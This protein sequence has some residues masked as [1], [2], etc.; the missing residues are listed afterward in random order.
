MSLGLLFC[1]L[2]R[3]SPLCAQ[4]AQ[5]AA[6]PSAVLHSQGNFL[7][8]VYD[9]NR[10]AYLAPVYA[11]LLEQMVDGLRRHVE[12]QKAAT[13]E[14]ALDHFRPYP[15]L[16]FRGHPKTTV[17]AI[18]DS[19]VLQDHP[20]LKDNIQEVVDFTGEG[21]ADQCG[22][23][24][25]EAIRHVWFEPS[26]KLLILK[27]FGRS[28]RASLGNLLGAI[29]YLRTRKDVGMVFMAGGIDI[30][31]YPAGSEVCRLAD[32][33]SAELKLE[34]GL[35]VATTG[36]IGSSG[37][38]C[39]AEA[40]S[41]LPY[42]VVD[43]DTFV[44]PTDIAGGL[45]VAQKGHN[46]SFPDIDPIPLPSFY[47]RFGRGLLDNGLADAATS[48]AR[49]GEQFDDSYIEGVR[50]E[51][52]ALFDRRQPDRAFELLKQAQAKYPDSPIIAGETAILLASIGRLQEAAPLFQKAVSALPDDADLLSYASVSLATQG[53]WSE[54]VESMGRAATLSAQHL[55]DLIDIGGKA[56]YANQF[57]ASIA[58]NETAS[59]LDPTRAATL[60]NIAIAYGLEGN[61]QD[62]LK[63]LDR[64]ETQRLSFDTSEEQS[65]FAGARAVL[66]ERNV[67]KLRV[68]FS[69]AFSRP[70]N[71]SAQFLELNEL[72]GLQ[73]AA[74]DERIH[75]K[76]A[77][78]IRLI[79]NTALEYA[80]ALLLRP[81]SDAHSRLQRLLEVIRSRISPDDFVFM[82]HI[83]F[84]EAKL[85]L[86]LGMAD[87]ALARFERCAD[88][89]ESVSVRQQ[90]YAL[91]MASLAAL[92]LGQI[93][94]AD[95]LLKR[96][97]TKSV[98]FDVSPDKKGFVETALTPE[99]FAVQA[100]SA[101]EKHDSAAAKDL[102]LKGYAG[103]SKSTI[104]LLA[105]AAASAQN[106]DMQ[107]ADQALAETSRHLE[108]LDNSLLDLKWLLHDFPVLN[109]VF[110]DSHESF[111]SVFEMFEHSSVG[112][113]AGGELDIG[114]LLDSTGRPVPGF[115]ALCNLRT[116]PKQDVKAL[117]VAVI[118][119]GLVAS[120]PC[121]AGR[122]ARQFDLT[123][124]R[125]ALFFGDSSG[126]A[127]DYIQRLM[128]TGQSEQPV[129][130]I[131]IKIF[132][133]RRV[134]S[135]Q[136]LIAAFVIARDADANVILVDAQTNQ[137]SLHLTGTIK[138][139][140]MGGSSLVVIPP[141]EGQGAGFPLGEDHW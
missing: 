56:F 64:A 75:R 87:T 129:E 121:F 14:L 62:A 65:D 35:F 21:K 116:K 137:N 36:N 2:L 73:A 95:A 34:Y 4:A 83:D 105:L 41:V 107:T 18:I 40:K 48:F 60:F 17:V 26:A 49:K 111:L 140:K 104:C 45:A 86:R 39:P 57:A 115:E 74:V 69:Y 51:A 30:N 139:A 15:P 81:A 141:D 133:R 1:A 25:I 43:S 130:F 102:A 31:E 88:L 76:N 90:E 42:T 124:E 32:E 66:L 24:T 98:F 77:A 122:V 70:R 28:C 72:L 94:H 97:M 117:K 126:Q 46:V 93:E 109:A 100:L 50:L 91:V 61:Y 85:A 84:A 114:F 38:W 96:A 134:S 55:R 54:G 37:H 138:R 99:I 9:A 103:G 53:K 20:L 47:L 92:R 5:P 123:R 132:G 120:H 125:G 78:E 131:D 7:P 3:A 19:G 29:S 128:M 63:T 11:G 22:H 127:I 118:G 89:L 79:A 108:D 71:Y 67:N 6:T 136:A 13:P 135:V 101:L 16:A 110:S 33:V 23:G 112:A 68:L 119:T 8:K 44:Q 82:A 80:R 12:F 27:A 59:K 106:G 113:A 52:H 10:N 58:A